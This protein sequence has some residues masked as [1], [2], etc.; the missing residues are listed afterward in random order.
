VPASFLPSRTGARRFL[1]LAAIALLAAALGA[2]GSPLAAQEM[3]APVAVQ[4]PILLK[5]MTFDRKLP[6]RA[7]RTVVV[8]IAF[9]GGNRA[10]IVAKD[11]A[12]RI[13]AAQAELTRGV[14]LRAVAVDLDATTLPE[15]LRRHDLTH[16]YV[17]PLRAVDVRR[18]ADWARQAGVTTMTGVAAHLQD[19]LAIGVGLRGGRPRILVNVEASRLEGADLS[20]ELLKLAE[21]VR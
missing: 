20:S 16:L 9:Q 19:G 8:G 1:S 6:T 21:I 14:T 11:E 3:E 2:P 13:I 17:T 18:I 5:V 15:A 10:S 7:P 4:L 12:L